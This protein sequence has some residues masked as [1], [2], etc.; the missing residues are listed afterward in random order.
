MTSQT[1][2]IHDMTPIKSTY[3]TISNQMTKKVKKPQQEL[4]RYRRATPPP[5]N[6]KS[7]ISPDMLITKTHD[8]YK[9]KLV[10]VNILELITYTQLFLAHHNVNKK[11][12]ASTNEATLLASVLKPH[13][14]RH[15]PMNDDPR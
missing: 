5:T 13:A 4:T 2:Y 9:R 10:I 7:T 14:M 3:S 1:T 15:A 6:Q 8:L 11:N 12:T